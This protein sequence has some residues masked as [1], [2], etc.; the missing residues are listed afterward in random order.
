MS[1]S[2]LRCRGEQAGRGSKMLNHKYAAA[3]LTT[4]NPCMVKYSKPLLFQVSTS[5]LFLL[6]ELTTLIPWEQ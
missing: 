3:V 1:S 6:Q 4:E 2:F 5:T